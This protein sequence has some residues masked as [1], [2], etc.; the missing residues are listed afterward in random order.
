[1]I[2]IIILG[3]VGA[4]VVGYG[5]YK[6]YRKFHPVAV[7]PTPKQPPSTLPPPPPPIKK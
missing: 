5:G 3:L 6:V 4:G 1:M 7:P 2:G